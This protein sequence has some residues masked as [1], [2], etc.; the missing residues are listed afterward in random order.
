MLAHGLRPAFQDHGRSIGASARPRRGLEGYAR[1][2]TTGEF[3]F[4]HL[5]AS[6]G[7]A[8]LAILGSC[9]VFVLLAGGRFR[10]AALIGTIITVIA[11]VYLAS[12]FGSA[13]F[14]QPG[15]GRA[16]LRGE[17]AATQALNADTAYGPAFMAT[18]GISVL[19]WLIGTVFWWLPWFGHPLDCGYRAFSTCSSGVGRST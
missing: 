7:G 13:A 18:A 17:T 4:S 3:L 16:Y 8:A 9:S 6:I 19:L 12:A 14:V 15:I 2:V 10:R 1:F 5:A 11:Q